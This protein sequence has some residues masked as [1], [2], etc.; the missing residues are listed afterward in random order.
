MRHPIGVCR[1]WLAVCLGTCNWFHGLEQRLEPSDLQQE[2]GW[3]KVR[4]ARSR[5]ETGRAEVAGGGNHGFRQPGACGRTSWRARASLASTSTTD[6]SAMSFASASATC[7]ADVLPCRFSFPTAYGGLQLQ[8]A[9]T[10]VSRCSV[11]LPRRNPFVS[12]TGRFL[13]CLPVP[14]YGYDTYTAPLRARRPL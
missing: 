1:H 5:Q 7:A 14:T 12:P 11:F 8:A 4:W 13:C 2:N 9:S 10:A 3:G 6:V